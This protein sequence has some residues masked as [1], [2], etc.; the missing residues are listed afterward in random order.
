M[1]MN[2]LKA[3]KTSKITCLGEA[4]SISIF[5]PEGNEASHIIEKLIKKLEEKIIVT[6]YKNP[7]PSLLYTVENP[8]IL[9]GNLSNSRCVEMMYYKYLLVTDL[10]YPGVGGFEVRTLLDPFATGFNI[11]HLGYSD[12]SGL[13]KAFQTF[14]KN[15]G[16]F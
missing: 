13:E 5:A 16:V 11:L 3:R 9:I 2:Y 10:T 4:S 12:I 8:I 14:T 6:V 7:E 1:P 15:E